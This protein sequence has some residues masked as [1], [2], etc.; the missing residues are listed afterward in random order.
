MPDLR[1]IR[2]PAVYHG[3][4]EKAPFFEGWYFKLV[5]AGETHRYTIIPGVFIGGEPGASHT[6]VQTLDGVTGRTAYHRY[7]FEAFQAASDTFDIRIGPNRFRA[8]E[9]I[10]DIDRPEGQMRGTLPFA[11]LT[12]WPVTVSSPGIMGWYAYAPFME[13]YHG[14]LSFDHGIWGTLIVDGTR[15]T[16]A[17]DGG[18]LK[19][20]GARRSPG[21]GSGCR[22]T[23]SAPMRRGRR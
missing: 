18:T 19:R 6:F 8:D 7:P 1:T 14:V 4:G 22:A 23:T 5:D 12:P 3:R 9:I 15:L 21:R 11:G 20:T 2:N 10:L 17:A 16:S 13:C